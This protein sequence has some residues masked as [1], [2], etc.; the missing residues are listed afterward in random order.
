MKNLRQRGFSL[1]ELLVVVTIIVIL[2]SLL[3]FGLNKALAKAGYLNC[4]NNMKQLGTL[5]QE[6]SVRHKGLFPAFTQYQWIG[7][8]GFLEGGEYC[9]KRLAAYPEYANDPA[10]QADQGT[11]FIIK[12][13]HTEIFECPTAKPQK[14]NLQG[15]RSHYSGLGTRDYQPIEAI[16]NPEKAILLMEYDANETN[17]LT[18][19]DN[20]TVY[21]TDSIAVPDNPAVVPVDIYRVARNHVD[22]GNVLFVDQHIECVQGESLLVL[23]WED[24]FSTTTTSTTTST[25]TTSTT[26]TTTTAP[27]STT[28]TAAGGGSG[29]GGATTTTA[30]GGGGGSGSGGGGSASTTTTAASTSTTTTAPSTTSTTSTIST[31]TSTTSTTAKIY[32]G[33]PF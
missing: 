33:P 7:Q 4:Q 10:A 17:I 29:S 18:A 14:M 11:Y 28:T 9:W 16:K 27:T 20:T 23:F 26:S 5:L 1:I 19:D 2:G 31:T 24:D 13:R 6:Y 21:I 12:P 30:A 8:M 32:L 25:S 3:M 15:V 22:C